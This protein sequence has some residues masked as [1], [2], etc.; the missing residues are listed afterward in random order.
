MPRT[1]SDPSRNVDTIIVFLCG[2][3]MIGRG[4]DH[5]LPHPS[6]PRLYESYMHTARGYVALAAAANGPIP[7][8][9]DFAYIW[10]D[11]LDA[12]ARLAPDVRIVNLETAITTD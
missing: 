10:G 6:D 4:F 9:V 2:D 3:V 11:A 12:F 8:P 1:G 5:V 7:A